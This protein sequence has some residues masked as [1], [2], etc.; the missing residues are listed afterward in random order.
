[1]K[2]P[3]IT[4]ISR[5]DGADRAMV[6]IKGW[7]SRSKRKYSDHHYWVDNLRRSGWKGSIYYLW[8]DSPDYSPDRL[9][10]T[11]HKRRAKLSGAIYLEKTIASQIEESSVSLIGHSL[12]ARVAYF[13][14]QSWSFQ[15]SQ[16]LHDMILL[17]GATPRNR[18]WQGVLPNLSGR[19]FNIYNSNDTI[20]KTLYRV[21]TFGRYPCGLRP[22]D[23]KHPKIRNTDVATLTGKN[24]L[25]TQ[26]GHGSKE[27]LDTLHIRLN[28]KAY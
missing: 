23:Y 28:L 25:K 5:S 24:L 17:G 9:D 20:L 22:I 4:K 26:G 6:I 16:Q 12:G 14:A 15:S 21:S 2:N 27:Y 8:W 7:G 19:V 13:G 1:M 18:G 11:K 3:Y 10:W